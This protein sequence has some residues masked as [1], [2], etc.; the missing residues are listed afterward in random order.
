MAAHQA[1]L[2]LG[3]SR[4]EHWSGLPF[5]SPMHEGEKWK[6]SRSVVSD[7]LRPYGLQPTRLLPSMGFSRQEYWNGLLLP[8]PNRLQVS[9]K[10][11]C[12]YADTWFHLNLT[13]SNFE[14]TNGLLL[15]NLFFL[16]CVNETMYLL[17]NLP[18]FIKVP[19]KTNFFLSS[20]LGLLMAQQTSIH[21]NCFMTGG[22]HTT[23]HPSSKIYIVGEGPG[24][25]PSALRCLSYLI[26]SFL[27]GIKQLAKTSKGGTIRPP[28]DVC[29]RSFLCLFSHFNKTL[30]HKSTWVIKHG[31]WSWSQS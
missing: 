18:F 1:P 19:L 15:Q 27:T 8:S 11:L 9:L 12:C 24:E 13:F 5:P 10:I 26:N 28:S 30:L 17:W 4:Q 7:S 29:V 16:S 14:L 31:P 3:F 25:T 2:S 21:I 22:W 23:C 20:N 6:W